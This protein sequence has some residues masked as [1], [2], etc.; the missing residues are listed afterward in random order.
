MENF[1]GKMALYLWLQ[2]KGD[3]WPLDL[4]LL[5][6]KQRDPLYL[7]QQLHQSNLQVLHPYHRLSPTYTFQ[8]IR[9][10]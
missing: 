6:W 1:Q 5:T 7:F 9:K 10:N 3:Y 8:S 4:E 2:T